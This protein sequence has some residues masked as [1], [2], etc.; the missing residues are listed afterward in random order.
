VPTAVEGCGFSPPF[1]LRFFPHDVSKTDG[2][3]E[4]S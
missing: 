1:G 3:I 2:S 4:S